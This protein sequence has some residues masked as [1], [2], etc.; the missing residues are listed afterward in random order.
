[1]E[2]SNCQISKLNVVLKSGERS[3]DAEVNLDL[4]SSF[5]HRHR[6]RYR[7]IDIDIDI[8]ID[9]ERDIKRDING[10]RD[11]WMDE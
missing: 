8:D 4:E 10:E 7:Y 11:E 5:I 1:M 3:G 9:I 6:H 2:T